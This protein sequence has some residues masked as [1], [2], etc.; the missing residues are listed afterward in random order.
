MDKP[1]SLSSS[2]ELFRRIARRLGVPARHAEDVAQDALLR[3][4]EAD[5]R[6][7]LGGAPAAYRVA[8]AA[9]QARDHV[10]RARRRG[11]VLTSFDRSETRAE[12]PDPEELLRGRQRHARVRTLIDRVDPKYRHLLIRH[13]LE[14]IPLAQIAAELGLTTEAVKTQHRRAL[15]RLKE[16][17]HRW[18]AEE[19]A[20]GR[21][22]DACV[23]LAFGWRRRDSWPTALGRGILRIIVQGVLVVLTGTLVAEVA[24]GLE[25]WLLPAAMRAPGTAPMGQ[26]GAAPA[27]EGGTSSITAPVAPAGREVSP[28]TY[29]ADARAHAAVDQTPAPPIATAPRASTPGSAARSTV[30]ER[31]WS[32]IRDAR[33]AMDAHNAIADL[34]ARRLLEAHAREFPRGRLARE[35]EALLRQIR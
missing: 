17:K 28:S 19:R 18:I 4:L 5:R 21:D 31:E 10:R 7:D 22:G 23:P 6:V 24:P 29:R 3:G 13:D 25:P 9:N 2:F 8:I 16:E 1:A 26:E 33:S 27:Q 32:L 12:L 14:E 34:E 15:E 30:S 11:E 20:R 35:R